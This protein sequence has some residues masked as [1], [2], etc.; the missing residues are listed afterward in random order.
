MATGLEGIPLGNP[1][2]GGYT[3]LATFMGEHPEVAVFKRFSYLNTLALLHM[4]AELSVLEKELQDQVKKDLSDPDKAVYDRDWRDLRSSASC[5]D[6]EGSQQWELSQKVTKLVR[7]YGSPTESEVGSLRGWMK[8]GHM[9]N[10]WL[11]G[12][13]QDVWKDNDLSELI[14]PRPDEGHGAFARFISHKPLKWYHYTLGHLFRKPDSSTSNGETVYYSPRGLTRLEAVFSTAL[15]SLLP[16]V[17]IAVLYVM[18]NM[19]QRLIMI[20]VFQLIFA[21]GAGVFTNGRMIEI[22]ASTAA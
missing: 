4:Q 15:A 21:I 5:D 9:G 18:T 22:F 11:I 8:Y 20:G 16:T 2:K 6:N 1:T 14:C 19:T 3:R 17:A 12:P 7:D 13:D 10:M